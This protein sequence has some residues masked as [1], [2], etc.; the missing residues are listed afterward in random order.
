MTPMAMAEFMISDF[1]RAPTKVLEHIERGDIILKRR[2]QASLRLT[3]EGRDGQRDTAYTAMVRMV[4]NLV[5]HDSSD[6]GAAVVNAFPWAQFLS[7][8][9]REAFAEELTW[10]L[11]AT[12]EL[13][14]AAPVAQL[15]AEWRATA[16]VHADPELARRL[17]TPVER[18]VADPVPMPG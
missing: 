3:V 12:A 11:M 4:R 13:E 18:P 7:D 14:T 6:V 2:G 15:V 16:A 5:V 9:E 17:A 1:Q 10:T 8:D